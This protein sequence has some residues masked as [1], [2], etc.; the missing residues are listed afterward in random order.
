MAKATETI[1]SGV[2]GD[3]VA[4]SGTALYYKPDTYFGPDHA[5]RREP[6]GGPILLNL[7]HE[8][9][10]LRALVGEIT[11]VHAMTS[12][13]IRGFTVEDTAALTFRFENGALGTFT[14][15]D[16]AASNRSW[17]HTARETK[18]G[19]PDA[20]AE[21]H[22]CCLISG[23]WGT[24]AIPTLRLT[25]YPSGS[26]RSW[27]NA[28]EASAIEFDDIDPMAA[29]IAHFRDVIRGEAQPLVTV[30]DGLANVAV[31]DAIERSAASG[32]TVRVP[33]V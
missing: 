19:F 29:Q 4:A 33:I 25:R 5:W 30:R 31:I 28:M 15:S 27:R 2:L 22:D 1:R 14:L 32:A 9:D 7:I 24:L 3:I 8:I 6:G 12:D 16:T 20:H 13:A 11:H 17:E 26:E 21:E 10:N 23:T 18:A